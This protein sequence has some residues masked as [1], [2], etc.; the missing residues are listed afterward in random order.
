MTSQGERK[1]RA[2]IMNG[3]ARRRSGLSSSQSSIDSGS[4]GLEYSR[5]SFEGSSPDSVVEEIAGEGV[6][7]PEPLE[8]EG[9]HSPRDLTDD[10][11]QDAERLHNLLWFN[12]LI[13][14]RLLHHEQIEFCSL[15]Y[16]GALVNIAK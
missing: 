2:R 11:A 4:L 10:E 15:V 1:L 5:S 7:E 12:S 3:G 8:A 14:M 6:V 13:M 9:S 16:A